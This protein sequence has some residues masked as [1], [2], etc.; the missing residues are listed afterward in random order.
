MS[1]PLP[2]PSRRCLFSPLPSRDHLCFSY[3]LLYSIL[4]HALCRS[5]KLY[6]AFLLSQIQTLTP[7]T[8]N[9]LIAGCARHGRP[10]KA[11]NLMSRMCMRRNGFHP[12]LVNYS[13]IS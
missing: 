13:S 9:A 5:E 8:Y 7:L 2:I 1:S 4:I 11:L 10:E 3:E 6:E 12:D